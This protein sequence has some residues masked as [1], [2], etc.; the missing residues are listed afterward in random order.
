M[1]AWAEVYLEGGGW[2]E[3]DPSSDLAV[4]K[5]HVAVAA[6]AGM[7]FGIQVLAG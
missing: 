3:Y 5:G 4:G 7:E 2:R 6:E 1:H